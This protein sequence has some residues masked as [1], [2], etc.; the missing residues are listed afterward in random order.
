MFTK[1]LRIFGFLLLLCMLVSVFAACADKN[2][3]KTDT[4]ASD[5]TNA[6]DTNDLYDKDG[7]L[8][9][10]LP[11]NLNYNNKKVSILGWITS[12]SEFYVEETIGENVS[13][14]IYYRNLAVQERLG[15]ELDFTLIPGDNPNR[16]NF[17]NHVNQ[18]MMADEGTYDLIGSYSMCAPQLALQD[19]LLNLL[20][21]K[22]IDFDKPWWPETLLSQA[23]IGDKLYFASGDISLHYIYQLHFILFNHEIL[24]QF[25][26][27]DPRQHVLDGTWTLDK[28]FEYANTDGLYSDLNNNSQR[29]SEDR[30]GF[31]LQNAIWFDDFYIASDMSLVEISE[32]SVMTL[33]PDF[34]SEKAGDLVTKLTDFFHGS[35][36][37]I[38]HK[39]LFPA[40][41]NGRTL[42]FSLQG[43]TLASADLDYNYGILPYP[44]YDVNQD[45]Y[46]TCVGFAY[47][48][49]CIPNDA[50]DPEMSAAIME[51]LASESYR[52]TT[53]ALFDT[54]FKY[55]YAKDALDKEMFEIIKNYTYFDAGRIFSDSFLWA[56][57]PTG[58][59]RNSI[60]NNNPNWSSTADAAVSY[61]QSVLDSISDKFVGRD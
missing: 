37:A 45:E 32:E 40:L 41:Y 1:K 24:T 35:P 39:D 30:Y 8:K 52:K 54:N 10:S 47:T 4:S 48:T 18:A 13:D 11:S 42:F 26:L 58:L 29:D 27:S 50:A 51:C 3:S 60:A 53:V 33:S 20:D 23:K 43:S 44:K 19:L 36:N 31:V 14:A 61:I 7:Y 34:T 59:F 9:D 55:R 22:Y 38:Y 25:Q 2:G 5:N 15:V 6:E 57:S 56:S 28:L 16:A 49:F 21:Y 46:Y 17:V 12:P